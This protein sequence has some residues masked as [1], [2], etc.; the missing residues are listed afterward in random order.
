MVLADEAVDAVIVIYTDPMISEP[1]AIVEAVRR[2][3]SS[4]PDKTMLACFLAHDL[5][6]AIELA[7]AASR[8]RVVRRAVP[9][10]P[11]PESPAVAL[12]RIAELATWRRRPVGAVVDPGRVRRRRRPRGGA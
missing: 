10:F 3:A 4:T 6:P 9:V 8:C 5:P 7:A 1:A 2:A 12:G 11:F